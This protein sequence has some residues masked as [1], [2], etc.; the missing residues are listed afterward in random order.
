MPK[1]DNTQS[2]ANH[3]LRLEV[4]LFKYLANEKNLITAQD[5]E[6]SCAGSLAGIK[7]P[8]EFQVKINRAYARCLRTFLADKK[9]VGFLNSLKRDYPQHYPETERYLKQFY[10]AMICRLLAASTVR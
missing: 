4:F 6:R 10:A 5:F 7:F 1:P 3:T 2:A 8:V 9:D